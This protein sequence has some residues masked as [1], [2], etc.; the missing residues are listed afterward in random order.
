MLSYLF[1]GEELR[2]LRCTISMDISGI[3]DRLEVGLRYGFL[4]GTVGFLFLKM[5]L[6]NVLVDDLSRDFSKHLGNV[7]FCLV[8]R[9]VQTDPP[10]GTLVHGLDGAVE[11]DNLVV[12]VVRV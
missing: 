12:R 5:S 4:Q 7:S 3:P 2:L 11:I 8:V 10:L 6:E 9:D 1:T